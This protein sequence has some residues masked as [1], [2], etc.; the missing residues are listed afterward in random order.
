MTCNWYA[1][2]NKPL[3]LMPYGPGGPIGPGGPVTPCNAQV[4]EMEQLSGE[5]AWHFDFTMRAYYSLRHAIHGLWQPRAA[6]KTHAITAIQSKRLE[7]T[8][9]EVN[10]TQGREAFK[11]RLRLR[12]GSRRAANA[13]THTHTHAHTHK[14]PASHVV[15]ACLEIR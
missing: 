7:W 12:Q 8:R 13:H 14:L 3:T 4:S 9:D 1:E 11:T 5:W 15:H 10:I 6:L 2:C